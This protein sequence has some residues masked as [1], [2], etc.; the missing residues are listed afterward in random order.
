MLPP[1]KDYDLLVIGECFVEFSCESDIVK[2]DSFQKDIGGADIVTAAAAARLGSGVQLLSAVA[3]D[4]FHGFIRDKLTSQGIN[5]DHVNIGCQGFNGIYFTSNCSPESREYLMHH[6]GSA[7][8]HIAPSMIYDDLIEK[9]KIVYASSELQSVSKA[10][11]HTIF[12]AFHLAHC[13]NTMVAYDPN[14]RLHRWE[15]IDDAR[16][17]LWSVL[18]LIDVIFP[19]SPEESKALFGYERP[20]DVIGFLWDRGVDI[21]VVKMGSCGCMVGHEGKIREFPVPDVTETFRSPTLVGSAFNGG[22]LHSI[23]AGY[24]AFESAE[25]ANSAALYKG[26]KGSGIDSLP[27]SNDLKTVTA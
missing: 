6:P 27:T 10:A 3:R 19:S 2:C 17:S 23:A 4:P 5:I 14:L 12:K 26:I 16:E 21:V 9:S 11:R 15:S 8:K 1:K 25:L 22:Y 13:N 7:A 20:L 24:D 18:P